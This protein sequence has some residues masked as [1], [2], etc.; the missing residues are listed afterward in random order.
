MSKCN[1]CGN[2]M[3]RRGLRADC[4]GDCLIC[5]ATVGDDPDS[6]RQVADLATKYATMLELVKNNLYRGMSH[7]IQRLQARSIQEVL[8]DDD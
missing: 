2:L 3:T 6:M 7:S 4:G 5:M 8:R 1:I